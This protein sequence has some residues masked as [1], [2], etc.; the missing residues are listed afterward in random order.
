MD[1]IMRINLKCSIIPVF[2][3][4]VFSNVDIYEQYLKE[5]SWNSIQLYVNSFP[6]YAQES[7][8]LKSYP[9]MVRVKRVDLRSF[10]CACCLSVAVWIVCS[11]IHGHFTGSVSDWFRYM[12]YW[13]KADCF[14]SESTWSMKYRL[15]F[16]YSN[17][18]DNLKQ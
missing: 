9:G 5:N 15:Q 2:C 18:F 12:Y 14:M 11:L 16:W 13:M 7:W 8:C 6:Q 10:R 1:E 17:G 4:N 3:F